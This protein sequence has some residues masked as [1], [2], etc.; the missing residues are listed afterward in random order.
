LSEQV[1]YE[2]LSQRIRE[3]CQWHRWYMPDMEMIA[4]T[5][6]W[7]EG[8]DPKQGFLHPPV[9]EELITFTEVALGFHL[10]ESLTTV[11]QHTANGGYGP[12]RGLIGLTGGRTTEDDNWVYDVEGNWLLLNK[13]G[14]RITDIYH[15]QRIHST[16]VDILAYQPQLRSLGYVEIPYDLM[17]HQLVIFCWADN[18]AGYAI[19]ADEGAIYVIRAMN[20]SH[21]R[22]QYVANSLYEWFLPW[23][24][25]TWT[26]PLIERMT[27]SDWE[28]LAQ[29]NY[30]VDRIA[31]QTT[32]YTGESAD[33]LAR[34]AHCLAKTHDL[35]CPPATEQQLTQA[36]EILPFP[37]PSLLRDI[38]QQIANGG[39][40]PGER[41]IYGVSGGYRDEYAPLGILSF[42]TDTHMPRRKIAIAPYA[43]QLRNHQTIY[44]PN[45]SGPLVGEEFLGQIP[46]CKSGYTS[47]TYLD[48]ETG[49]ILETEVESG[50]WTAMSLKS[51]SFRQWWEDWLAEQEE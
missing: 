7:P 28:L 10:P 39:F 37:L 3:H 40:G 23:L 20:F 47:F 5:G 18:S 38:Y 26:S 9:T 49:K 22:V 31:W 19:H 12:D 45:G 50:T 16:P 4:P 27:S 29:P 30:T 46:L 2:Y 42:M 11:Y 17:I 44:L 14:Q 6:H 24:H 35:L 36:E 33:L 15:Y 48:L 34:I 32:T 8:Y 51:P 1:R 41:G 13:L 21:Y 43:H 25:H